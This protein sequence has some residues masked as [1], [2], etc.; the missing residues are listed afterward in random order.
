MP[1]F[2]TPPALEPGDRIAV[3][4][5]SAP[6]ADPWL[7]IALE[8]LRERFDLDP[9]VY[10]TAERVGADEPAPPA[11]RAAEIERAF[12]DPEIGGVMAVTGGD[13]QLRLLRHLDG[14]VLESNPTRFY[15]FSDNDNLRLY[16]WNR[17]IVSYG[18]Q[19]LPTVALDPEI[20]PY[21]ERHLR[22]AFFEDALGP[23][24]PA[25]EWTEEW[26]EFDG[27]PREWHPNDGHDLRIGPDAASDA[28]VSGRVWGG[29]YS[30]VSWQLETS[31]YLPDPAEL[32][33][34]VLALET[35]E[36]LPYAAD[37][38]YTLRSMGERGLLERFDGV[39]VGRPKS[40]H[41]AV[42]RD[43]GFETYRAAIRE[44]VTS[45]LR[46]Y[47]PDAVAVF[48]VDFGHTD[49]HFPLPLGGLATLDAGEGTLRFD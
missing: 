8:R 44:A 47:A 19:L 13:D 36:T 23:V 9:V 26:Y 14:D 32:D 40:E 18:A 21:T 27:E 17:G 48:G 12:A 41:P 24:E 45:Q 15:G 31:R 39:L 43:P 34:A 25:E 16:L 2:T 10:P 42:E 7:E 35:S 1:R 46:E 5:P 37:V 20:H 6:P 33:G 11:E 29:C 30:I 49:P 28:R 3:L 22:R 4:A 38:G